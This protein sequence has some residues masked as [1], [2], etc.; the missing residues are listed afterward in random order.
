MIKEFRPTWVDINTDNFKE[1]V[2]N[3]KK[4]LKQDT[5]FCPVIKANAYGHGAVQIGK[6]LEEEGADYLGVATCEEALE[7]RENNIKIPIMCMGY[8]PQSSFKDMLIN[9]IDITLYSLEKAKVFSRICIETGKK[10]KVHIKLD[11]GMSR[12]GFKCDDL[13]IDD[14]VEISSLENLEITG[15]FTHFALADDINPEPTHRQ[16]EKYI[17]IINGLE[18]KGIDTGIKHVCN[19]AGTIMFPQYHLDMVRVGI[20]LYGH[21]PSEDV[22]KSRVALKPAMSLKSTISHIK[23]LEKGKGVSYGH[24]YKTLGKEIIAT[25]PI[26][27]ADG[28]TRMLSGKCEV[29]LKNEIAPVVGRIC[30]DQTMIRL[31]KMADVGDTVTIFSDE[32]DFDIERFANRLGTINYELLCM[33]Q[34]RVP[35]VYRSKGAVIE[36][37]DYLK[38]KSR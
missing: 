34:R 36:V 24:A 33:V 25:L 32:K 22:D 30:M 37:V 11:T 9:D 12:L 16:F 27:Y 20:S 31:E 4:L 35:R 5:K 23:I 17:K 18:K 13:A 3:I 6:I 15:I 2:R 7:L 14:I 19:S 1:N 26:G 38:M 21:Y 29:K 28:F 10:G 8:V